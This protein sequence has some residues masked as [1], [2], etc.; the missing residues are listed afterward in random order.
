[1]NYITETNNRMFQYHNIMNHNKQINNI[2]L[3]YN[4]LKN[5]Y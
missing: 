2:I 4:S 1:M 5:R 3:I